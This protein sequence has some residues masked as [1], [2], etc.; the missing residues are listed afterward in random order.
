MAIINI[1]AFGILTL[2]LS[3]KWK[4]KIVDVLPVAACILILILYILAFFRR[5]SAIDGISSLFLL[6]VL[7]CFFL[8]CRR[9]DEKKALL[10]RAWQEVAAPG[11]IVALLL[12]AGTAVCVSGRT[13]TWW[14]D[15]NFW[16]TD[17][18][19]IYALDGFAAKYANAAPEFGDYPPGAQLIKWWFVH[20]NP[21][22][23][24]E[25]L[26][27]AGYY[28]GVFVFLMPLCGR[29][30]SKNPL[31]LLL[32]A[33]CLWAFPSVAEAFYCQGM[34]ADLMMAAIYGAFLSAVLE[35]GKH[36]KSF[37]YMRLALYLSVLVL[38]KS[39]GFL[40][41]AFGLVFLWAWKG[42]REKSRLVAVT[43]AP[44]LFGGS[45]M[46]FCLS[47]R[48]VAKLTGAALS[49]ASGNLPVLLPGTR[50]KLAAA[51]WEAFAVWP[52]HR[53]RT[54]AVDFSPLAMFCLICILPAVWK[55]RNILTKAQARL[56]GIFL[57]VSGILFYGINFVSHLTIFAAETQYLE[58]FAMVSSIER[59]GAPFT[60]GSLYVLAFMLL[61]QK[62]TIGADLWK[63]GRIGALW[64]RDSVYLACFAFVLL[65]ANWPEVF[66]GLHGY[67]AQREEELA[68]RASMIT[69]ESAR[70]LNTVSGLEAGSGIRILYLKDA[71]VNQW[72]KNTYV[73]YEASPVSLMFGSV[74]PETM[75]SGDLWNAMD[76][77]HAGYLY[78]DEIPGNTEELF[79][80]FTEEIRAHTL[81][82]IR[83]EDGRIRLE[84]PGSHQEA[85]GEIAL[86][87]DP[88]MAEDKALNQAALEGALTYAD[89]AD[90]SCSR[91][92]VEADSERGYEKAIETAIQ[93]GARIVIC[94]GSRFEQALGSLQEQYSDVSFL[95]LDGVVRDEKGRET[96][97]AD[98]VHCITYRE[99]EAGFLAG[100]LTVLEGYHKLGFIGGKQNPSVQKYGYG[101]LQ[102]ID[103]A[104]KRAGV[105]KEIRVDYWYADT[106]LAGKKT[107]ETAAG[108]YHGGT[109]VIFACGGELYRSV[110]AAAEAYDGKLIGADTDQSSTS[111]R[112]LTSAMKG[113]GSSVISA[114]DN[115]F[116][117]GAVW[118]E[119]L[120]G[121]VD[122]GGA[123]K[124]YVGLPV[125]DAAWRFE[126][127]SEYD[128]FKLL[129]DL[130][131]KR[132]EV[133]DDISNCPE[134]EV[135][136]IYHNN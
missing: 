30:K 114:L 111:E 90:I 129:G 136:V 8:R 83:N 130:K 88:A 16:A 43:A 24:S 108:W 101:Y 106:F 54:W 52:L 12:F 56:L 78:L 35:E 133:S 105:E 132:M 124:K 122:C 15:L 67:R 72:V 75:N 69:E 117:S 113:V 79:A 84:V 27:F 55:K 32:A 89:A 127:I 34:C 102:G 49:I 53:G 74:D 2:L 38:V 48:R 135:M 57:P 109:E 125:T 134:T 31:F 91:Y 20:M 62:E 131:D 29:M 58:P 80:P 86:V 47:M 116:A 65:S 103:A 3:L 70:F 76:A 112:F 9:A 115:F 95:L 46:L 44:V 68:A 87:I 11:A 81:Y 4:E 7:C 82:R 92:S 126:N 100:Y 128:Y 120:A 21:E 59:Y 18:K 60:I 61:D 17:V 50:G 45:W 5:L 77:S 104:A 71:A 97:I 1:L 33:V 6:A 42:K 14:D 96:G 66:Y 37:Y 63:N 25:G 85:G 123:D 26:M 39:V 93:N 51:F 73:A 64:Q 107:E 19:A 110:L 99:E 119:K 13:A 28:F 118:P 94:T 23:F 41:A 121:K 22:H 10:L 40:W 36:E 98:N